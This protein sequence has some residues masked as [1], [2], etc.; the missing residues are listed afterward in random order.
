MFDPASGWGH[1]RKG[2]EGG[3]KV[4]VVKKKSPLKFKFLLLGTKTWGGG[5]KRTP[6]GKKRGNNQGKRRM[7]YGF[8]KYLTHT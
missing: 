3:A 5:M 8:G 7:N 6:A 2:R 1:P 4:P